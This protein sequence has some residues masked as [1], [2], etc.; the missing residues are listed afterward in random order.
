MLH[1]SPVLPH[2]LPG[3]PPE[4][5]VTHCPEN[6]TSCYFVQYTAKNWKDSASLCFSKFRNGTLV[7]WN[8]ADEQL[9]VE[10]RC[11]RCACGVSRSRYGCGKHDWLGGG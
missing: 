6:G 3:L 9:S 8:T 1:E 7:N 11:G 2:L 10:Q 5:D 4:T